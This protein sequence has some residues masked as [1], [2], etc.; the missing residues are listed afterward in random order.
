MDQ[1]NFQDGGKNG[2][3]RVEGEFGSLN[4]PDSCFLSDLSKITYQWGLKKSE[5][6][7]SAVDAGYGALASDD[8]I[9]S[10]R[11]AIDVSSV[12]LLEKHHSRYGV[13]IKST[14][15][16]GVPVKIVTP[17][18]G[19]APE[20]RNK[21]LINFHGGSF[22]YG[23]K[24]GGEIESIP[25]AAVGKI[26]VV[27]VD[28][29]M[30]PEHFFPAASEDACAVYR[31]LLTEY[32]PENIGLYGCSAGA[33]LTAQSLAW[34]QQEELPM[35]GAIG[36]FAAGADKIEGDSLYIHAALKNS[37]PFTKASMKY[38][39]H[40]DASDP[41]AFPAT[42]TEVLKEF[43]PTLL[44]SSSRDFLLSSVLSTHAKLIALG[45]S[46][47]LHAWEGLEHGFHFDPDF[48]ESQQA[49]QVIVDHFARHLGEEK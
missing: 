34:M 44:I 2:Q 13:D 10:L 21:V 8:L 9:Y 48:D 6:I 11:D 49:Y 5:A 23:A 43:P 42:S 18:E 37:P 33:M 1:D 14:I 12:D 38:F 29:R 32:K 46:A 47:D 19:V 27:T 16:G 17:R 35:P 22:Q 30:A 36:L 24:Y 39:D 7:L 28:Y 40:V 3:Q 25:I 41:L 45:V 15:I 31:E 4:L 20:N 26:K